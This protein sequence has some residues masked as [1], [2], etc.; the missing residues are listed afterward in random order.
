M[1]DAD[2]VPLYSDTFKKY[3]ERDIVQFVPF[4]DF[5]SNPIQL[6]KKTLEEVP[7]QFLSYYEKMKIIPK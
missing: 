2:E 5:K 7:N 6:A 4:R 3:M 1:L